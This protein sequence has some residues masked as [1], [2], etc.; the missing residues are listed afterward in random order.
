MKGREVKETGKIKGMGK[1]SRETGKG[2]G[3]GE[4]YNIK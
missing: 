1:V 2:R 4:K 3:R